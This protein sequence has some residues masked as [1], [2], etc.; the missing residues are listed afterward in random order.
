MRFS[1]FLLCI[2]A[3]CQ[4]TIH[5]TATPQSQADTKLAFGRLGNHVVYG[6]DLCQISGVPAKIPTALV[7]QK[8]QLPVGWSLLS[9]QMALM[10]IQNGQSSG[11]LARAASIGGGLAAGAS[12]GLALKKVPAGWTTDTVYGIEGLSFL[13]G[14]LFP[15]LSTHAIQNVPALL[16]E[17]LDFTAG[18]VSAVAL[19]S[20]PK[21]TKPGPLDVSVSVP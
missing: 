17:L 3:L 20:V 18:C 12:E 4:T 13:V 11:W 14:F 19:V 15:A 8:V 1:A 10:V 21:G 2:P 9:S 5:L 6:L 7:R 16:P